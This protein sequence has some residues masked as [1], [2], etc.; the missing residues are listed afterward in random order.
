ML[1]PAQL[2]AAIEQ[3]KH[4]FPH[5][6]LRPLGENDG[7]L[8]PNQSRVR[9]S[10][11]LTFDAGQL[12]DKPIV[13]EGWIDLDYSDGDEAP[14]ISAQFVFG[15]SSAW[16]QAALFSETGNLQGTYDAETRTWSFTFED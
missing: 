14:E 2:K 9:Y 11:Q 1:N 5:P 4:D 10:E 3:A 6:N 13:G 15:Y 16:D 12:L 8:T 7:T